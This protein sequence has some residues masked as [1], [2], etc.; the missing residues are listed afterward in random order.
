MNI[1]RFLKS[2]KGAIKP[3]NAL[4]LSGAVGVGLS[5]LVGTATNHQI[6]AERQ[7]RASLGELARETRE[8]GSAMRFTDSRGQL[9]Y[10]ENS[11][12]NQGNSAVD[13]YHANQKAL[14]KMGA[15]FDDMDF[16]RAA[17]FSDS[18]S[19]LGMGNRDAM[20]DNTRFAVGNPR[21]RISGGNASDGYGGYDR[22]EGGNSGGGQSEFS[23]ASM[24]QASGSSFSGTY[25]PG[26]SG[27]ASGS[28]ANGA[29]Q[30]GP[31]RLSG[32]MPSGT[33]I[34]SQR[35]LEGALAMGGN[36]A[37]FDRARNGRGTGGHRTGQGDT[38]LKDILKKSAAAAGNANASA[39]EGS[40]AFLGNNQSSGGINVEGGTNAGSATSSDLSAPTNRK[41]KAIGNRLKKEESDQEKRQKENRD[42]IIQLFATIIGSLGAM[43]AGANLLS[44][45]DTSI[46]L[47]EADIAELELKASMEVLPAA[48]AALQALIATQRGRL[49]GIKMKRILTAAGMVSLVG[50][51]SAFLLYK[52]LHFISKYKEMGGVGVGY[53][54]AAFA[55]ILTAGATF[56][57]FKPTLVNDFV[58]NQYA[59]LYD[60]YITRGQLVDV[61][62]EKGKG[63]LAGKIFKMF[64]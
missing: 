34:V 44:K 17:Q 19:G 40:K 46:K 15:S 59:K 2:T 13:R 37:S 16:G 6:K 61:G 39:T 3:L 5:V 9:G 42:L 24:A 14:G 35:G 21:A 28:G 31:R 27:G 11:T 45:M 43:Y 36:T 10:G 29:G 53:A 51:A 58:K 60:K 20:P 55:P 7:V 57:A 22:A 41:L 33:N 8:T 12:A 62:V 4:I 30:E 32:A 23:R 63:F 52:A 50:G 48:K 18:D 64:K 1:L 38:E 49:A 26:A 25:A 47:L 56:V 54:A